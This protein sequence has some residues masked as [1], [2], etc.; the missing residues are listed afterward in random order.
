MPKKIIGFLVVFLMI[1]VM[2][3]GCLGPGVRDRGKDDT[4]GS[5]GISWAN[6]VPIKKT[7][8]VG[9]DSESYVDDYAYMAAVPASVFY[10]EDSQNLYSNPLL[11]YEAPQDISDP[12]MRTLN[13]NQGIKYFMEDWSTYVDGDFESIELINI[14]EGDMSDVKSMVNGSDF[15]EISGKSAAEVASKIAMANWQFS[16]AAVVAVVEDDYKF[17][18][19]ITQ[20]KITGATPSASVLTGAFEGEAEPDPVNPIYHPFEIGEDYKYIDAI[21]TWGEDYNPIKDIT[22]RGKD[23]DLQLYDMQ[24]GEVAASCEWNVL[25]GA[26]EHIGSYVYNAGEWKAAVTYMPTEP[27]MEPLMPDNPQAGYT[28]VPAPEPEVEDEPEQNEEPPQIPNPL[29]PTAKYTIDYTLYPGIDLELPD[30][31]P[32]GCRNAY[33][34]LYWSDSGQQLGLI[35]RGSS[36]AEIATAI[37]PGTDQS[38]ELAELGEG[39]YSVAVINIGD[40]AKATDFEVEYTWEQN[41][42]EEQIDWFASAAQGAVYASAHNIPLLYAS[43]KSLGSDTKKALDTL[44]VTKVYL[45]DIGKNSKN[46]VKDELN[47]MRSML[48]DDMSVEHI[49]TYEKIYS[50]IRESTKYNDTYQNDIVFT[51]INPWSY[52]YTFAG[53]SGEQ[54]RGLYIGPATYA[55]AHHGCPVFITES[56]ARLSNSQAWHNEYWKNAW[57]GRYPPSVGCMVLSAREVYDYIEEYGFDEPDGQESILTVAGQFDIG[58]TWDRMMVGAATTGRIMGSPVDTGYWVSRSAFYQSLIFVN[59]AVTPELDEH[60]GMRITGSKSVRVGGALRIVEEEREVEVKNNVAQTWVSYQHRFNER[61]GKYWGTEY[62]TATGITPFYTRSDHEL[63]LGLGGVYPDMT[64]SEVIPYYL[65]IA[66]YDSVYTCNF[67]TSMENI[68]RGTIMWL[69]V[70]HGGNRDGGIV[71]FWDESQPESNPWRGYEENAFTLR[72]STADP[73]T[74]SMNKHIGLDIQPGFGGRVPGSPIETHDGIIIAIAQ[75][76]Q[77]GLT[78]GIEFDDAMENLHSM[79]FSAG[80]CLIANTYLQ[81]AMVR[82]GSVFQIIDPWLTSWYSAFAMEMF[83]RD[84]ILGYNVGQAYERGIKHVGIQYLTE[85]WWWDIFENVVYF[86]DPDLRV[87][88]PMH[89][90]ER[91]KILKVGIEIAGHQPSGAKSHPYEIKDKT[92]QEAALYG[93]GIVILVAI[94]AAYIKRDKVKKMLKKTRLSRQ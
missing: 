44:G 22:E 11:F 75:Q 4:P 84:L 7:T 31:A 30:E 40:N 71:G 8:F 73:D 90:W 26:S 52:W 88:T 25:S 70:M 60:N 18:P 13:A 59:P 24:L 14:R 56:D 21:M 50:M 78:T 91:P 35:I 36:G 81:L 27:I 38:I 67:E 39:K 12:E 94:V 68:N 32:Y 41:Y 55:A 20:K 54:N 6:M 29:S 63:E 42:P 86:G 49:T 57:N 87:Y 1:A 53:L 48:Q 83:V 51:T 19:V 43:S 77:T 69:E 93:T 61:G 72:G 17:D 16:D 58:T 45:V 47:N 85:S 9:Y 79:G 37:T 64:S 80:S 33:F 23:P 5:N 74:V 92:A 66:G 15:T 62:V 2:F 34:N 65:E 3:S 82:H 46:K 10:S 89:E 28:V 76:Q